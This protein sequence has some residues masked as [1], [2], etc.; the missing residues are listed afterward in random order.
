MAIGY[1][2]ER[3]VAGPYP[4]IAPEE[5]AADA[6]EEPGSATPAVSSSG[7]PRDS[8]VPI[9][10]LDLILFAVNAA[11]FDWTALTPV[12]TVLEPRKLNNLQLQ[13]FLRTCRTPPLVLPI[14]PAFLPAFFPRVPN[15]GTEGGPI[16]LLIGSAYP[17]VAQRVDG[18]LAWQLGI[19][20][21]VFLVKLVLRLCD[22]RFF[23]FQLV[24][25]DAARAIPDGYCPHTSLCPAPGC[26]LGGAPARFAA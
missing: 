23:G 25:A 16:T 4:A 9:S 20:I 18:V 22:F 10:R 26:P 3:P 6:V 12:Q 7:E 8:E 17:L 2:T 21:G 1:L 5:A 11:L 14:A 15:G 24:G 19:V 13:R